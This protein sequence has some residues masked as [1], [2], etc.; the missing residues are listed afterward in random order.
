[1]LLVLV[2]H[3]GKNG[4]RT[5]NDESEGVSSDRALLKWKLIPHLYE[6]CEIAQ[7]KKQHKNITRGFGDGDGLQLANKSCG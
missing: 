5:H 1:M 4:T 3:G 6:V 2:V 7:Q